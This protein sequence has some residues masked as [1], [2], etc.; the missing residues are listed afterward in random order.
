MLALV[1]PSHAQFG[2]KLKQMGE[3]V[4]QK[5]DEEVSS[6]TNKKKSNEGSE[7][8]TTVAKKN[9]FVSG[10]LAELSELQAKQLQ[11]DT[12]FYNYTLA[13]AEKV[14]FFDSRDDE[15]NVVLTASKR[16]REYLTSNAKLLPHEKAFERNRIGSKVLAINK[17][18][19]LLNFNL[20][21]KNYIDPERLKEFFLKKHNE[22]ITTLLPPTL[23]DTL[24]IADRYALCK[25]FLNMG[26]YFHSRGQYL[27]A[28]QLN[29]ALLPFISDHLGPKSLAMASTY[30]NLALIER[31]LGNYAEAETYLNRS[32]EL[33]QGRRN[34]EKL[35][36]AVIMN[37]QAMLFQEIGQ[38]DRALETMDEALVLAEKHISKKGDDYS[39][40][41][42]NKAVIFKSQKQ[43]EAAETLLL[44][45]KKSKELRFGKR[46]QDYADIESLLAA[47]YMGQGKK[48]HVESLLKHA[49]DI[50]KNKFSESHPAYTST[51]RLLAQ[52]Y[53]MNDN[54]EQAWIRS[55]DVYRLVGTN[56]G[57]QHPDY[58][59]ILE[60]LAVI[61]WNRNQMDSAFYYFHAAN[62]LKLEQLDK[63]F[64][65]LSENEKAKLWA[66]LR[67]SF[68]KFYS[69]ASDYGTSEAIE[70]MYNIQLAIKGILLSTTTKMRKE[71]LNN[72]DES[73]RDDYLEWTYLKEELANYY[74]LSKQDL[75]EQGINL[76]SIEGAANALEKRMSLKS[77]VFAAASKL[78][79]TNT[80]S[81]STTLGPD[82][83]AVEIIRFP[84]FKK[85][86][87]EE[88]VYVALVLDVMGIKYTVLKNGVEM[89]T[90]LASLYR[91]S[92]E[93]KIQDDRSY[94]NF[95]EPVA[96]LVTDKKTIYLSMDGI[97]NQ[98]N[99]NT[100]LR[101]DGSY[102]GDE[103]LLI[104]ISSTRDISKINRKS[105]PKNKLLMFGFPDYGGTGKVAALPGTKTELE[106][107]NKIA[108][109]KGIKTEQYLQ[110][111][112][113]EE[114]FK[115]ESTNPD[116]LH[117]ATHGFFLNDLTESEEIVYGVEISKAKEN[118][119]LRSG[120]MLADAENTIAN[121]TEV[122]DANNG[123]LTAYEAMTLD[124]DQTKMVVLSACETGLGEIQAG[125]GVYGLQRAFQI[126]GA[127]TI[128]MS[129]WKV[130]DEATQKLMTHFY[131]E[132]L[133]TGDKFAAFKSAQRIIRE[134][135]EAPY[136]WGAFVMLN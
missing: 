60:D 72:E 24:T 122:S 102:L 121:A 134:E 76:D 7:D 39:K 105:T 106:E 129:L 32:L 127:E 124:L 1:S 57:K 79:T 4:Q 74:T 96:A 113:N 25:T 38:Y 62:D 104:P 95:W 116:V 12:S 37:N 8:T 31:D 11:K 132:W 111:Q 48:D 46:H 35:D 82:E 115:A 33:I 86:F 17:P 78:T 10:K 100:L 23:D 18:M 27:H 80:K 29:R 136:Y 65:A 87:T 40:L 43:Y 110:A 120:L 13:Q 91:R 75:V 117:I 56:F 109:I 107:I 135:Y 119:L 123:I 55:K 84:T 67:P 6:L 45:L 71:I 15:Q 97:Y 26:I 70:E 49:L 9:T 2:K 41:Q 125:E 112:A 52:F 20:A 42:I 81:L 73:L 94:N 114:K 130:N 63:F 83:A 44:Q 98:I 50:Y 93:F 14:A 22:N 101:P 77:S 66:K 126:A 68:V 92:I 61:S 53:F 30:N 36:R 88:I 51:Q 85:Q 5:L 19:A 34:E 133:T 3:K 58:Q 59:Q 128:I 90:R 118:P 99:L 131:D 16:Y 21:L 103:T 47:V 108:R 28:E 69:F 89:E 54:Y 64:P